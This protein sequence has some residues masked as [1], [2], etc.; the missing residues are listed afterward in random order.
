MTTKEPAVDDSAVGRVRSTDKGVT[1]SAPIVVNTLQ[2]VG[3]TDPKT[4]EAVRT[5]DII[6]NIAVD[7]ETGAL[8]VRLAGCALLEQQTR[9][10]RLLDV[11][12][13]RADL[14][15]TQADQQSSQS[16]GLHASIAATDDELAVTYYDF[17]HD[18]AN[19]MCC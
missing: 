3:I 19:P 6:P 1:W 18:N 16:A 13:W 11:A 17:R 10:H 12:G 5:G 14:V 4:G 8:H 15:V 9:R 7:R 2:T